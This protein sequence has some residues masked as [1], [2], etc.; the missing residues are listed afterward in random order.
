MRSVRSLWWSLIRFGFRL[1]YNELAFTYDVVSTV[2][3]LGAWGCWQQAALKYINPNGLILELAHGTGNLQ[4]D[5]IGA[6]HQTVGYDLSPNMGR[7]AR[8]KLIQHKLTPRLTRGAAQALPFRN[9]QFSTVVSTFPS[10]FIVAKETLEEV[11]RVLRDDGV[12]VIVPSASFTGGGI[13]KAFLEWL[14]RITGQQSSEAPADDSRLHDWFVP[15]G[16]EVSTHREQCPNSM[17]LVIVARK[18]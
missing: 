5:L 1:L 17:T 10:D 12:F 9:G 4:I 18:K 15:Y 16:F 14:Y 3:S 11:F 8:R 7:I 13:A 6:G 2:V